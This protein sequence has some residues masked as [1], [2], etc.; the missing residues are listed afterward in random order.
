MLCVEA[1]GESALRCP[2]IFLGIKGGGE[3]ANKR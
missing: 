2:F 3:V 1:D